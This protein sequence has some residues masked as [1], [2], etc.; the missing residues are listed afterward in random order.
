MKMF[1]RKIYIFFF[2]AALFLNGCAWGWYGLSDFKQKLGY[3]GEK[4]SA[5]IDDLGVPD[6]SYVKNSSEEYWLYKF[7]KNYYIILFGDRRMK[8]M[9]VEFKGDTVS[10]TFIVD[11]GVVDEIVTR[12]WEY[13][14]RTV[15]Y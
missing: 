7:S 1:H 10:N 12:G 3:S 8:G 15:V 13:G 2:L 5:I 14:I 6:A 4:K 11:Q 9:I